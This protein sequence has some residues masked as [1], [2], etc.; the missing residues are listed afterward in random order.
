L[1]DAV[2]PEERERRRKAVKKAL[3]LPPAVAGEVI[4]K[5]VERRKPRVLVGSDAKALA[6]VER[7]A[8]V[9]YWKLLSRALPE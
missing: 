7:L 9:S 3:R 6:A 5:G 2:S 4:V 8:P 1:S